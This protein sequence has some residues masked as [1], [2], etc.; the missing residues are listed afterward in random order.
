MHIIIKSDDGTIQYSNGTD[1][2]Q[3]L[4][5]WAACEQAAHR[6][7]M[8]YSGPPLKRI[9]GITQADEPGLIKRDAGR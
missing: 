8:Q 9:T 1:A 3:I 7:G 4:A 2:A 5:W 6:Q